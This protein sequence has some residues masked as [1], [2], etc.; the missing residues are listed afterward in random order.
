MGNRNCPFAASSVKY[1]GAGLCSLTLLSYVF[2]MSVWDVVFV[3]PSFL[4]LD[5]GALS[6]CM[7]FNLQLNAVNI[8]GLRD[9]CGACDEGVESATCIR[10]RG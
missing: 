3:Q 7:K 2:F 6:F 8:G 5:V 1:S 9:G 10:M 4:S